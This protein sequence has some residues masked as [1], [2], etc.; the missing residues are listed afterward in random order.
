MVYRYFTSLILDLMV[1]V[2]I[3]LLFSLFFVFC[4]CSVGY[5]AIPVVV[6]NPISLVIII[7]VQAVELKAGGE[8]QILH[9]HTIQ[10]QIV[11]LDNRCINIIDNI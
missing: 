8:G 9:A 5:F 4:Y 10:S 2:K 3:L 7:A 11:H 1:F 6:R